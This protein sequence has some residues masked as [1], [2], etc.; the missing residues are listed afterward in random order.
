M[1]L[2]VLCVLYCGVV[3]LAARYVLPRTSQVYR[4]IEAERSGALHL[5]PS[6]GR[7][8]V[9]F[10]GNSLF[11]RGLDV[12]LLQQQLPGCIVRRYVISDTWFLD[13]YYGLKTL[14]AKGS[15]PQVVVIG[16]TERQLLAQKIEGNLSTYLLVRNGDVLSLGRELRKDNSGI[17]NL[18]F[19]NVSAFFGRSTGFRKWLLTKVVPDID[20]LAPA[21]RPAGRPLPGAATAAA[22]ATE[23]LR[24]MDKLCKENGSR[25]ILV[26]PPTPD[27]NSDG[28]VATIEEAG[29]SAGVLV[30]VP[31]R[32]GVMPVNIFRDG[33]H[34]TESGAVQFT[35]LLSADLNQVIP[36]A[37]AENTSK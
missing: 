9:L 17:S 3:E 27:R 1:L 16:L 37:L 29:R 12:P 10:I 25:L 2:L 32:P 20:S 8:A 22:Q 23:R 31:A 14:Y 36:E 19:A 6:G 13:W 5:A 4:R 26:I 18:Y 11:E 7:Q 33:A 21:I 34:L 35:T 15:R 24:A 30:L 28:M